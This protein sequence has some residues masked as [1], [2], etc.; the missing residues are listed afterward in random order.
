MPACRAGLVKFAAELGHA[1]GDG[2]HG[3]NR[4]GLFRPAEEFDIGHPKP[5][6]H[7]FDVVIVG[8]EIENPFRLRVAFLL[9]DG[10]EQLFFV[11]EVHIERALGDAGGAGNVVHAGGIE[12]LG[13]E[14]GP[15]AI[16]D[17]PPFGA[18]IV[19]GSGRAARS[20]VQC[21]LRR[22]S[23]GLCLRL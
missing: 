5:R 6:Q 11:L 16:D 3:A 8:I 1:V 4:R 19:A 13:E 2:D 15:G 21:V 20:D 18:L 9:D 10:L 12:A 17:L 23:L 7:R 22:S 14:H